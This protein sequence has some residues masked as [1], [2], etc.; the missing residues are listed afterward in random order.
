[1]RNICTFLFYFFMK[2]LTKKSKHHL[3]WKLATRPSHFVE[4]FLKKINNFETLTNF[5]FSFFSNV[6]CFSIKVNIIFKKYFNIPKNL[7]LPM[8]Q[9]PNYKEQ[10]VEYFYKLSQDLT[11]LMFFLWVFNFCFTHT[12]F[13]IKKMFPCRYDP[14]FDTE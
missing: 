5:T 2:Y 6:L 9:E 3:K 12:S 11:T 13:L 7:I 4:V 14:M 10:C 8:Q 1:M